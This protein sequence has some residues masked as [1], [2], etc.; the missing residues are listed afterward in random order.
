MTSILRRFVFNHSVKYE[1]EYCGDLPFRRKKSTLRNPHQ[2]LCNQLNTK[3]LLLEDASFNM[4]SSCPSAP[5]PTVAPACTWDYA[6]SAAL[7]PPRVRCGVL[8]SCQN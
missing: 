1:A 5:A 6:S 4:P 7:P 2:S 8:T 3:D